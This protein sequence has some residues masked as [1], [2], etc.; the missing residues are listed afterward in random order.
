MWHCTACD[1]LDEI[2]FWQIEG[3]F[4]RVMLVVADLSHVCFCPEI[5]HVHW[6][7][8]L[9]SICVIC[10][11]LGTREYLLSFHSITETTN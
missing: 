7:S 3:I 9:C 2:G 8:V 1:W 4:R 5:K 6:H 10:Q 11:E